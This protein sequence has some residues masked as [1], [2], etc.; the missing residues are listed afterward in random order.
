MT[1][2]VSTRPAEITEIILHFREALNCL[3]AYCLGIT[4]CF[5]WH[6]A[7]GSTKLAY[8]L[9]AEINCAVPIKLETEIHKYAT[10]TPRMLAHSANSRS[11][12]G[13]FMERKA[14]S[15][16]NVGIVEDRHLVAP[17]SGLGAR[18]GVWTA[19]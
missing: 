5:Y 4:Q 14:A 2:N 6:K 3:R 11:D 19:F 10:V 15:Y 12:I 7:D 9:I 13:I 18:E 16:G 17:L 1:K 8:A